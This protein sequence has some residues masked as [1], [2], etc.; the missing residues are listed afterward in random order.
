[1]APK[2]LVIAEDCA[3]LGPLIPCCKSLG[4]GQAV[5]EPMM[6]NKSIM[7]IINHCYF[8]YFNSLVPLNY[9]GSWASEL[10]PFTWANQTQLWEIALKIYMAQRSCP[11]TLPS[12]KV[13]GLNC[14]LTPCWEIMMIFWEIWKLFSYPFVLQNPST[15][16]APR[17]GETYPYLWIRFSVPTLLEH[18]QEEGKA[19]QARQGGR[20]STPTALRIGMRRQYQVSTAPRVSTY[21]PKGW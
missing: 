13:S 21:Y 9:W 19:G 11:T 7:M 8:N 20:S 18:W 3:G 2:K 14:F 15:L 17:C 5:L 4:L 10:R 12:T 1:M 16:A 6:V